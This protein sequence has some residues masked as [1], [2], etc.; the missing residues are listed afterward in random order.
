VIRTVRPALRVAS[1]RDE[2]SLLEHLEMLGDGR[3][4]EQK[5]LRELRDI[6]V[7]RGEP[8][9][10]RPPGGIGERRKVEL[11]AS[12]CLSIAIRLYYR[13]AEPHGDRTV[14]V[15]LVNG[16]LHA[17]AASR[18]ARSTREARC[19]PAATWPGPELVANT[20]LEIVSS[21]TPLPAL[22]DWTSSEGRHPS[23]AIPSRGNVRTT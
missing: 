22:S 10:D 8:S 20:L 5:R 2:S 19:T 11:N 23:T 17:G 12:L 14:I 18:R 3:L 6:R 9:E 21:A 15:D 7:P 4:A 1:A 13:L 16:I